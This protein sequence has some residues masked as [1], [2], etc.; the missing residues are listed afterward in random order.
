MA[1]PRTH[2]S[3]PGIPQ[4]TGTLPSSQRNLLWNSHGRGVELLKKKDPTQAGIAL[5]SQMLT[6]VSSML[7]LSMNNF[8]I[9]Y[10]V[11]N[12]W[13]WDLF[14][15]WFFHWVPSSRQVCVEKNQVLLD[16]A[17]LPCT[18]RTL[19]PWNRRTAQSSHSWNLIVCTGLGFWSAGCQ[20]RGK[21]TRTFC[22]LYQMCLPLYL[23]CHL[24]WHF[25]RNT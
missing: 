24:M 14:T 18:V 25:D 5:C 2:R 20:G 16:P 23:R 6:D 21:I 4:W 19:N 22:I 9:H 12:H 3:H 7:W 11:R 8:K 13:K 17:S 15:C 1:V 10:R